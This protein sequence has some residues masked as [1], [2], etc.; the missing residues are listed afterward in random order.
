MRIVG[1]ERSDVSP[2]ELETDEAETAYSA[3]FL[4]SVNG[5]SLIGQRE[6][7]GSFVNSYLVVRHPKSETIRRNRSLSPMR[8][9][10]QSPQRCPGWRPASSRVLPP[11]AKPCTSSTRAR[12][13]IVAIWSGIC[14]RARSA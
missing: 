4:G 8:L 12:S 11:M 9:D 14:R 1:Q 2:S 13:S 3:I 5:P 6:D 10:A 7:A